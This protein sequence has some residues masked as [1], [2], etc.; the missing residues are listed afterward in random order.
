MNEK[1]NAIPERKNNMYKDLEEKGKNKFKNLTE[2]HEV[3][4]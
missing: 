1:K 2:T 3:V 4:V